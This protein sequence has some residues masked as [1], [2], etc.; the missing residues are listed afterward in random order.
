MILF[1]PA[2][3]SPIAMTTLEMRGAGDGR[4]SLRRAL[5]NPVLIAT[6]LALVVAFTGLRVPWVVAEPVRILAQVAVPAVLLS[7][8][9][10][11]VGSPLPGRGG[12][13]TAL[14]FVVVSSVLV[15]PVAAWILAGPVLGAPAA[16]V[17][18]AVVLSSLPVAQNVAVWAAH[19]ETAPRLARE[20]VLLTTVLSPLV[21]VVVTALLA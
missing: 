6:A 16:T 19:Y 9:I 1:Q 3:Q 21:I 14:G 12:D 11:L 8:G 4:G 10:S 13:R 17:Y 5:A 20:T 7:F 18:A 15:R 2:V